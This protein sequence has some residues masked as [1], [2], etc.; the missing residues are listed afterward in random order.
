MSPNP[1]ADTLPAALAEL[2][3][4][5]AAAG[6]V[7]DPAVLDAVRRLYAAGSPAGLAAAAPEYGREEFL[8]VLGR[9]GRPA[10]AADDLAGAL[11]DWLEEVPQAAAWLRL[12][13]LRGGSGQP[14]LLAAR[15]LC[16]LAGLRHAAVELLLTYPPR[17]RALLLQARARA[18]AVA[19]G[20]LDLPVA[21]HV[22]GRQSARET[23]R[24]EA[25]EELALDLDRQTR[26]LRA[27]GVIHARAVENPRPG[28]AP[29]V[30]SEV[31]WVYA[32]ALDPA[33]WPDLRPDPAEVAGLAL[34]ALED[35]QEGLI[36]QP[37]RFASGIR[38]AL[39]LIAR[40]F[41]PA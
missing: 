22:D 15:W 17:P 3:Q 24:R 25:R 37:E 10:R 4:A 7:L 36:R 33:A 18:K 5:A 29:L 1:T 8:L 12:A 35:V 39:P 19:P 6:D 2:R 27:I 14:G 16:H 28:G 26:G 30:D 40:H 13:P 11:R 21:G 38:A 23:L 20:C 41:G 31:R 9:E 34:F 32:A